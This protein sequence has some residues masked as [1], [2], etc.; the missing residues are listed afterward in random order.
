MFCPRGIYAW[1]REVWLE[2]IEE[3][4]GSAGMDKAALRLPADE[5]SLA[6]AEAAE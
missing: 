1:W 6:V 4:G 5:K 3:E 2:R